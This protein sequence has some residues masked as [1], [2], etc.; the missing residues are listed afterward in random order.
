MDGGARAPICGDPIPYNPVPGVAPDGVNGCPG[1]KGR[2]PTAGFPGDGGGRSWRDGVGG[3]ES[4]DDEDMVDG[5]GLE[6]IGD[7]L[8]DGDNAGTVLKALCTSATDM[9]VVGVVLVLAPLAVVA[10]GVS[11]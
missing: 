1:T 11:P 9:R 4:C 7:G 3:S 5:G 8:D 6:G 10:G 2:K